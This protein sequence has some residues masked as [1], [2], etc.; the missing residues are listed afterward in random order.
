MWSEFVVGLLQQKQIDDK[1]IRLTDPELVDFIRRYPREE[2]Q[3][4]E[5]FQSNGKFDYQKYLAAMGSPEF[6]S[7]WPQLESMERG[8]LTNFKLQ[9]YIGGM[10]RVSDAEL[11]EK[12]LRDN[13]R[14]KVDYV[15]VPLGSVSTTPITIDKAQIEEYYNSHLEEFRTQEQAYYTAIK[16]AKAASEADDAKALEEITAIKDALNKGAD[17]ATLASEKTQDPS[18]KTN[19]GDLGWFGRGQ[20]VPSFD[21]AAF[22]MKDGTIS[23][24]VKTQFGYHLINRKAFRT[25]NGKDEVSAAHILI[26]IAPSTE[27][28]EA[29]KQRI[30]SFRDEVNRD[31]YSAKL[32]EYKLTEE[33]QKKL[34]RNGSIV[35]LGQDPAVEKFFF[36]SNPGSFTDV[37][38]RPDAFYV[39]RSDRVAPAGISPL[40]DVS[41]LI[42]RNLKTEAQKKMTLGRAEQVYGAVMGGSTLGD[43]AKPLGLTVTETGFFARS[44]RLPV[45]GQ[46]PAF[47]GTAFGLSAANRFSKPV[48]TQAGAAVLEFKEKLAASLDGFAAQRDTLRSQETM[49]LQN[50]YWDHWFTEI[51]DKSEIKDYRKEIYGDQY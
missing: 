36:E 20:M 7:F 46:D 8:R 49:T 13:E 5:Q 19:G 51:R 14:V 6:A 4:M 1:S 27:S 44:G 32:S 33:P 43:A 11:Q 23:E 50:A 18:G 17:F 21:S 37:Y 10:V 25:T 15:L 47:I 16:L 30:Q 39:Y 45:L 41:S 28:L 34:F 22:A 38:D 48:L 35:G 3:K 29:L 31:N 9:E 24:P 42:E 2:V 40:T 12:Y 26:K